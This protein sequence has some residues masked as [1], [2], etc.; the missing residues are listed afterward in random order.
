MGRLVKFISCRKALRGSVKALAPLAFFAAS[1]FATILPA[2][3]TIDN[4]ATAS[5]T[6]S[7][8][9]T[10]YGPATASVLVAAP[11]PSIGVVKS[12]GPVVD[13][14]ADGKVDAGDTIT[15]SFTA[16]N[17]GNVTLTS[18]GVS[19]PKVPG[20]TCTA[21]TLAPGATTN[22]SAAPY[23]LTQV[24]LDA[25]RFKT[26]P[27]LLAHRRLAPWLPIFP[28][29]QHWLVNNAKTVVALT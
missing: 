18:V 13:T 23:V 5:G 12:A 3:A 24:D 19:D 14:N 2:N 20:I 29:R 21:T 4:S 1:V 10:T 15:Y 22:C 11:A 16:S 28:I 7:S 25:G 17:L 27:L 8:T 9:T 26:R 6:Y